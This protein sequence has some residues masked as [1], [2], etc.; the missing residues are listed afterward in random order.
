M[1]KRGIK[2]M[3]QR[4]RGT[5]P[6]LQQSTFN[7]CLS[8]E[9]T[10]GAVYPKLPANE[11][12]PPSLGSSSSFSP[13]CFPPT[14][15]LPGPLVLSGFCGESLSDIVDDGDMEVSGGSYSRCFA[16]PKSAITI[17]E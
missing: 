9:R 11:S 4:G 13:S 15:S 16:I 1:D 10:S 3:K 12:T 8:P 17:G 5:Y 6:I 14:T 7:P 2:E